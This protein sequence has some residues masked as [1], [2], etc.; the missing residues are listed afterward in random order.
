MLAALAGFYALQARHLGKLG[1]AG[2]A[3]AFVGVALMLALTL[4]GEI[5]PN[6]PLKEMLEP[7][8]G[9]VFGVGL[10]G[11]LVGFALFGLATFRAG[12]VPRWCGLLVAVYP[13]LV[14]IS[15]PLTGMGILAGLLWLAL[16]YV[17]WSRRG[18]V[19]ELPSRAV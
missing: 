6:N 19:D 11:W 10:L 17:L 5:I 16:G 14:I 8:A 12:L 1:A 3:T 13:F 4:V 9:L 15:L 18:M 7:V 2:F